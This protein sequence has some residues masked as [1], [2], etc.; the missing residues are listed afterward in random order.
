MGTLHKEQWPLM[1]ELAELFLKWK[2]FQQ[3]L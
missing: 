3:T 2:K 1:L